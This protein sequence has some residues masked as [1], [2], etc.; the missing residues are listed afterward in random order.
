MSVYKRIY[1][2]GYKIFIH[3]YIC[4]HN[5]YAYIYINIHLYILTYKM[6]AYLLMS[7]SIYIYIHIHTNI[8]HAC[9]TS[10][11]STT[12]LISPLH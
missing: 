8:A 6:H 11:Q 4:T 10:E 2:R 7:V 9:S 5:T 3:A 12:V 1:Y